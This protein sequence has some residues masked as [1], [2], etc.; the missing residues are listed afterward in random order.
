MMHEK[1]SNWTA[2]EQTQSTF[3]LSR[4]QADVRHVVALDRKN[5]HLG[6]LTI[7]GLKL[8]NSFFCFIRFFSSSDFFFLTNK[9]IEGGRIEINTLNNFC[10]LSFKALRKGDGKRKQIAWRKMQMQINADEYCVLAFGLSLLLFR[11]TQTTSNS[12]SRIT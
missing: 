12:N 3:N 4:S 2:Y 1:K 8:L 7:V 11:N 9:V 10:F 5:K 6:T